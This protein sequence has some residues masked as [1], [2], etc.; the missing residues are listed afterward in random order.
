MLRLAISLLIVLES[1]HLL[2]FRV[3][4]PFVL[5][6]KV[7]ILFF[8]LEL[9]FPFLAFCWVMAVLGQ[10]LKPI[11]LPS[12]SVLLGSLGRLLPFLKVVIYSLE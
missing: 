6:R 11:E 7:E 9:T 12:S 10:S 3:I 2:T 1:L 5:R 4:V 8:L